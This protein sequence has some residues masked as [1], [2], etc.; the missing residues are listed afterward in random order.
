MSN[1][2]FDGRLSQLVLYRVAGI[3]VTTF[4]LGICFP[5][6]FCMI[7]RWEAKHTVVDGRRLYFDG[8]ATQ[9]FGM[10]IKWLLL[11]LITCGIYTFWLDIK[12]RQWKV[13]HTH[14]M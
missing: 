6:A 12:V 13:S 2:Y 5:W 4:T 7:Y 14:F 8:T 10:W 11:S 9:L 1:S 3:L